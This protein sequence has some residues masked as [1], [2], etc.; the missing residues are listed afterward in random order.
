MFVDP[1]EDPRDASPN[2]G[3]ERATLMDTLG[4]QRA[5][6]D[7]K[8]R[9]LSPENLAR[10]GVAP[11]K[12]SLLGLV[13]HMADVERGWFRRV[14]AGEDASKIF[15]TPDQP[16]GD[17]DGAVA[18]PAVVAEAW[19]VKRAEIAYADR[20]VAEA[21]D[22]DVVGDD[23]WEGPVA[24]GRAG[25]HGRGVR[26]PQRTRRP[27]ARA[28]RRARRPFMHPDALGVA[29]EVPAWSIARYDSTCSS[30]ATTSSM[31]TV[32][33]VLNDRATEPSR[34]AWGTAPPQGPRGSGFSTTATSSSRSP[35]TASGQPTAWTS[36]SRRRNSRS[37]PASGDSMMRGVMDSLSASCS[38]A[39]AVVTAT[40]MATAT[41]PSHAT[42]HRRAIL[43]PSLAAGGA[44]ERRFSSGRSVSSTIRPETR[45]ARA[46]EGR[47]PATRRQAEVYMRL[48]SR[49]SNETDA[50]VAEREA[51]VADDSP[52]RQAPTRNRWGRKTVTVPVTV[53][54][55]SV[56]RTMVVP[57]RSVGRRPA[58]SRMSAGSVLAVVVGA[59]LAVVGLIAVLR[60]GVDGTWFR[61]LVEVLEADHT[62][63]L[64]VLE[65]GAGVLLVLVG[66]T[67]RRIPVAVLGL[68]MAL[69]ATA[70]AIEPD[71]L[72]RELAI[73]PW[74]AWTLAA[75]G[76]VLVLAALHAPR[77]ASSAVVDVA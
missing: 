18:D 36:D 15:G 63:L 6:L 68:A 53:P 51:P 48:L 39:H 19:E 43:A 62:A 71:E 52:A 56:R 5:A 28:D 9:G 7:L 30:V 33:G 14:M 32:S 70:L 59:S 64:G 25:P 3:D 47:E 24:A 20:L 73:E 16:D 74:W 10:R 67:G 57:S 49:Q 58:W 37:P 42:R 41:G 77:E 38:D 69:G 50:T 61:P 27:A 55:R 23:P 72:Q 76:A 60:A 26:P 2:R 45:L 35:A 8:C 11:S 44:L 66:L 29:G 22:L 75:A 31:T 17:F 12:M 4:W 65:I 40:P 54:E 34:G 46:E 13:R 1:D 21:P